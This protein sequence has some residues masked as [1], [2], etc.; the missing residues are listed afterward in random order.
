MIE[1]EWRH[2]KKDE[3]QQPDRGTR[4]IAVMN[5]PGGSILSVVHRYQA[6]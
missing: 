2:T 4:M 1:L 3:E 6:S 5:I